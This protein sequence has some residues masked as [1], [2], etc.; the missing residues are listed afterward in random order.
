MVLKLLAH[1]KQK[2]NG[3]VAKRKRKKALKGGE[4]TKTTTSGN[5]GVTP[6]KSYPLNGSTQRGAALNNQN[7]MNAKQQ[8]MIDKH[9]GRKKRTIRRRTRSRKVL[10]NKRKTK[11]KRR[12]SLRCRRRC[13]SRCIRRCKRSRC[14][15]QTR[16]TRR[17]RRRQRGGDNTDGPN[18]AVPSDPVTVP[19]FPNPNP[20]GPVDASHNSA[21]GNSTNMQAGADACNDH[22]ATSG[23]HR[24]TRKM[25]GGFKNWRDHFTG[26]G[27]GMT[28][29]KS[30]KKKAGANRI[31][32]SCMSGG[33]VRPLNLSPR[34]INSKRRG[35]DGTG[36]WERFDD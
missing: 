10:K 33:K 7:E 12:T 27:E 30:R 17:G 15:R 19:S 9:G 29:G 3:G 22:Y 20:A 24:K 11:R 28:G 21:G 31:W 26:F 8:D 16:K 2:G 5:P 36:T 14:N 6:V 34:D 32:K 18:C 4:G 1:E 35:N 23:G 13:R 25:S